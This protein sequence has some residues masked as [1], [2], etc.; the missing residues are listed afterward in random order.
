MEGNVFVVDDNF[1]GTRQAPEGSAAGIIEWMERKRHPFKLY[2]EV[3]INL[4][5]TLN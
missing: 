3:S 2:T 1:I 5:T 4:A